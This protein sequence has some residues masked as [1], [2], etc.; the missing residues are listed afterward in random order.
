MATNDNKEAISILYIVILLPQN[1][2]ALQ[3]SLHNFRQLMIYK[4]LNLIEERP[5]QL[6]TTEH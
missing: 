6:Y 2:P 4:A 3:S 5:W 1:F